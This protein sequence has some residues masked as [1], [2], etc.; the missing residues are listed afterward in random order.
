MSRK[1]KLKGVPG[2]VVRIALGEGKAAFG[3]LLRRPLIAFFD[4]QCGS[5]AKLLVEELVRR[6]I[7]F[8]RWVMDQP[9]ADGTWP[10]VGH[11]A[12]PDELLDSPWFFKQDPIS[13]K[14][15]VVRTGAAEE[16]QATRGQVLSLERAAVW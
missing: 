13:G 8:R 6:P 10:V 12:V 2:D 7:A 1:R 11:V 14:I 5:D 9:I 15:T 3:V 4:L 16:R